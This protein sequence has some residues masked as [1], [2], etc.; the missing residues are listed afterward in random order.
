MTEEQDFIDPRHWL[1]EGMELLT[2]ARKLQ[3]DTITTTGE[4]GGTETQTF[5]NLLVFYYLRDHITIAQYRAGKRFHAL[6]RNS[7]LRTRYVTMRFDEPS[8]EFNAGDVALL[9][10]EYL[11]ACDAVRGEQELRIIRLVCIESVR[12]GRRKGMQMLRDGLDDLVKHFRI[13]R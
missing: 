2:E 3:G 5:E 1:P 7:C 13:D 10:R 8:G 12:A 9:P 4:R 6:W 11:E